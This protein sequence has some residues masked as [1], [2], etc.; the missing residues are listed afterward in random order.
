MSYYVALEPLLWPEYQDTTAT[1]LDNLK[2]E[3]ETHIADLY[4]HILEFQFRSVLRFYRSR[5]G[6]LGRDLV[7]YEDWKTMLSKVQ[8][9]EN[10]VDKDS[11]RINTLA[12]RQ[13]LEELSENAKGSLETMHQLLAVA[14]QL[15]QVQQEGL[16]VQKQIASSAKDIQYVFP[17]FSLLVRL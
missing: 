3:F 4:M 11:K 13:A 6:N 15:L 14:E 5:V 9:L 12:S 10:T 8:E 7:R 16:Q 2:K 1:G 17:Q